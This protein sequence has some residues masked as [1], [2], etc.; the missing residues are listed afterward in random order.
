MTYDLQLQA[1][2]DAIRPGP[3]MPFR[4]FALLL[5]LALLLAAYAYLTLNPLHP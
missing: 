4:R 2:I 5:T 1:R 3:L